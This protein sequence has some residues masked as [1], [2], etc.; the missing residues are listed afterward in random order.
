MI[1]FVIQAPMHEQGLDIKD[2]QDQVRHASGIRYTFV[3]R[4]SD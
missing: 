4:I 1:L 3:F 2:M